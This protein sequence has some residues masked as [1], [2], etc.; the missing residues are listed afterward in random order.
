MTPVRAFIC[1]PS[2]VT[3]H[4]LL[5]AIAVA[6]PLVSGQVDQSCVMLMMFSD[7]IRQLNINGGYS[8]QTSDLRCLRLI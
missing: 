8:I 7:V 1:S 2:N 5:E 3:V 4:I 6:E